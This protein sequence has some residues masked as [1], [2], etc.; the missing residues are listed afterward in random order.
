MS[1]PKE[2]LDGVRE[3]LE[4]IIE[5][6]GK[7]LFR[8]DD[9]SYIEGSNLAFWQSADIA[10]EA[11]ANLDRLEVV[12][13]VSRD[14]EAGPDCSCGRSGTWVVSRDCGHFT[15]DLTAKLMKPAVLLTL[16]ADG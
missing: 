10:T 11:L 16:K 8:R 7:C 5:S 1:T 13:G 15:P 3:A 12:D 9:E 2:I 14:H 4:A 6:G